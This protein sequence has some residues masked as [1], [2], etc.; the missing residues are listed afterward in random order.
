MCTYGIITRFR[1]PFSFIVVDF[2]FLD[3]N[4]ENDFEIWDGWFSTIVLYFFY[5]YTYK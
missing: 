1:Y 4:I 5:T 2:S 3:L